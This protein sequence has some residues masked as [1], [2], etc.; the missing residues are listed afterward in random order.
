MKRTFLILFVALLAMPSLGAKSHTV[1]SPD[2]QTS[3]TITLGDRIRYS[4]VSHGETIISDGSLGLTM[5]SRDMGANPVLKSRRKASVSN[6]VRPLFPLKYSEVQ[7]D[8]NALTLTFQGGYNVEWRVFDD[9]VAYRFATTLKGEQEVVSEDITLA[10]PSDVAL[11]LQQPRSFRTSHE[12][13]Y[14]NVQL[15]EWSTDAI[16][17]IPVVIT[18]AAHKV[19]FS[20][21]DLVQYPGIFLHSNG[22]GALTA[23]HPALPLEWKE[24]SDRSVAFTR[25]ADYIA[26]VEGTR[27][28]P[29]RYMLIT[30]D[31]RQ[32]V[33]NTMGV[34]L[35]GPCQLDDTSWIRPG[36]V[37]WEWWNGS[38]PYGPDVNFHSGLNL[39]TYKYFADFAAHYGVEYILMD[40]G[41]ARTTRDPLTPNPNIDL[42]A[43]IE[44]A[45]AEGVGIWLWLT[46]LTVEN[47]MELFQTLSQWGIKGV[48]IDFMDRQDQWMVDFY[49]RVA[50]EAAKHHLMVDFHGAYHPSGLEYRYPNIL[51][52]EGVR[53]MEQNGSCQPDNSVYLPYLRNAVGP[54]DYTP[55]AMI[56]MQPD[57]YSARRPNNASIG[58]RAYQM[59]L[60]VLFESHLT[61]LADNPTLYYRNDDCTRFIADV[62]VNWD[63]TRALVA[64]YGRH[65]VVAKR[66]GDHWWLGGMANGEGCDTTV[67]LDFLTP[68]VTYRMTTF[69]DGI[70]ADI[71]AM[72]YRTATTTVT[73]ADTLPIHMVRNGG[74]AA[75]FEPIKE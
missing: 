43:L 31:D 66:R 24:S 30:T 45:D 47:H 23:I 68:G 62:P 21:V 55:G 59:A 36:Q 65:T 58:T 61:M 27:T 41:W 33:Q 42:H 51:S 25:E 54:M 8:Y 5:G 44:H 13:P 67:A 3:V 56:S 1:V 57:K 26:R 70:N 20:E 69:T 14:T 40:E 39:E 32:L 22:A 72:D 73:S 34:R 19:L 29:W 46:W 53:G 52:F 35:A 4:I 50:R 48:K 74:I 17:E 75:S 15:S 12:E 63:E 64:S 28:F 60:Y 2:G 6:V 38:V 7:N 37:S 18:T 71:Q 11:T 16:C 10:F 9:G 49:E